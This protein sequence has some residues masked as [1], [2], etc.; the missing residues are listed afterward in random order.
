MKITFMEDT[1]AD[2]AASLR[3]VLATIVLC[4]GLYPLCIFTFARIATPG[5]ASGSLLRDRSGMVVGSRLIAQPFTRPGY[6]WPRPS[7][8]KYNAEGAGG[9]NLSPAGPEVRQRAVQT[10]ADYGAD[11][12]RPLPADLAAA[13]GSGLD[14]FITLRAALFQ[15]PRVAAARGM[16]LAGVETVIRRQTTGQQIFSSGEGLVNVLVLNME[17]DAVKKNSSASRQ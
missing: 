12:N 4:G 9:S 1:G 10:V 14:P 8:V 5:S 17:L 6:F 7:A 3:I 13:S 2:F 16:T 11:A 15:A